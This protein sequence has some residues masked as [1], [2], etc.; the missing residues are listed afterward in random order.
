MPQRLLF[1]SMIVLTVYKDVRK[2]PLASFVYLSNLR[3]E[4]IYKFLEG[5]TICDVEEFA[6]KGSRNKLRLEAA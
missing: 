5:L 2:F 3:M 4:K 6:G 1:L